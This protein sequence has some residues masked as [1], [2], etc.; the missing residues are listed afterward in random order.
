MF[1]I[2]AETYKKTYIQIIT[3][4]TKIKFLWIKVHNIR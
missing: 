1:K 2:N 3:V 4:Y